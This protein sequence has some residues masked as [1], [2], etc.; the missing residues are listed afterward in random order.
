MLTL[1]N[2]YSLQRRRVAAKQPLMDIEDVTE[3]QE[4]I[5]DELVAYFQNKPVSGVIVESPLQVFFGI[6]LPPEEYEGFCCYDKIGNRVVTKFRTET[7]ARALWFVGDACDLDA[8]LICVPF[9]A[10]VIEA[11][12]SGLFAFTGGYSIVK[13]LSCVDFFNPRSATYYL[14]YD[15]REIS[16]DQLRDIYSRLTKEE[17]HHLSGMHCK[18]PHVPLVEMRELIPY[19]IKTRCI[20]HLEHLLRDYPSALIYVYTLFGEKNKSI[21]LIKTRAFHDDSGDLGIN[22]EEEFV[23]LVS[24]LSTVDEEVARIQ[25]GWLIHAM[26]DGTQTLPEGTMCVTGSIYYPYQLQIRQSDCLKRTA[27]ATTVSLCK[28]TGVGNDDLTDELMR[29]LS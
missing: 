8:T 23:H 18:L 14:R 24:E 29:L 26:S 11:A 22:Q 15:L 1:G 19:L 5:F 6:T 20:S 16:L 21:E 2:R 9:S 13:C 7:V 10:G 17:K 4:G 3:V 27:I 28:V 25:A 12:L